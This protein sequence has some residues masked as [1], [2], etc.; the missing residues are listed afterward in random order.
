MAFSTIRWI[1]GFEGLSTVMACPAVFARVH[2]SHCDFCPLLHLENL[3][4]TVRAF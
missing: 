2:I 1:A 3:R 4:M